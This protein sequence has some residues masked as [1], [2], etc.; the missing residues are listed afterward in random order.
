MILYSKKKA[1]HQLVS[2]YL[3]GWR[4]LTFPP[5]MAVS[6]ARAGLTSLFGM[7]RG[8]PCRNSHPKIFNDIK[9]KEESTIFDSLRA[10]EIA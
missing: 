10:I 6:S 3:K 1:R 7:G 9:K 8:G 4:R 5:G 2:S